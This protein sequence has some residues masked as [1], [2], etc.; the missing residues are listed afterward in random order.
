M[1]Y[2]YTNSIKTNDTIL[3]PYIHYTN[4]QSTYPNVDHNQHGQTGSTC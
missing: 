1:Y 3:M 2:L 4:D